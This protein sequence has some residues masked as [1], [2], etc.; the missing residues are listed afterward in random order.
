MKIEDR[1]DEM[2][3]RERDEKVSRERFRQFKYFLNG[4]FI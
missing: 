3:R 2:S 4:N 1:L